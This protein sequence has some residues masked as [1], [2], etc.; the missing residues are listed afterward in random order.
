MVKEINNTKDATILMATP[1][2]IQKLQEIINGSKEKVDEFLNQIRSKGIKKQD[3]DLFIKNA[4]EE[5]YYY[6]CKN[7]YVIFTITNEFVT[8]VDFLSE[9]EFNESRTK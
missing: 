4:S 7:V 2:A 6:Q 8:L 1:R 5:F 9:I 3:Y